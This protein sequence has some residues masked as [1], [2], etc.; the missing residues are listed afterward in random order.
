MYDSPKNLVHKSSVGKSESDTKKAFKKIV[1]KRENQND[2]KDQMIKRTKLELNNEEENILVEVHNEDYD[3]MESEDDA[4]D[5]V[6]GPQKMEEI[7]FFTE[8]KSPKIIQTKVQQKRE[9][10]R[11]ESTDQITNSTTSR[12]DKFISAV[13]PSYAGKTKLELI[14]EILDLTRRNELLQ[15]KVKTYENTIHNLL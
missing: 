10:A 11:K 6:D 14:D 7:I 1:L 4:E 8:A 2:G 9:A 5:Q 12:E 15:T 3:E 13:Y